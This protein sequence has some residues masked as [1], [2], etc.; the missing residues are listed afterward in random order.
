MVEVI[1][2]A[3]LAFGTA[4]GLLVGLAAVIREVSAHKVAMRLI[5][6]G[7]SPS[8]RPRTGLTAFLP[9]LRDKK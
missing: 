3:A 8:P 1:H 2:L 4:A 5:D 6:R 9:T 7:D